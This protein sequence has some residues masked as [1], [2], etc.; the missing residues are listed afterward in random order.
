MPFTVSHAAAVL[1][2][3]RTPLPASALV[4]GPV[5]RTHTAAAIVTTDLLF[6]VPAWLL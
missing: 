5:I 2:L 3:L 1:P 6:G 4:I